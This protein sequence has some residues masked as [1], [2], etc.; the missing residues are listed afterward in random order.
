MEHDEKVIAEL[1]ALR[2][3]VEGMKAQIAA[4]K[5]ERLAYSFAEAGERIGRSSRTISRMVRANEME[6]VTIGNKQMIP[7]SELLRITTP[8]KQL[9][10]G[11]PP[12]KSGGG[13][14]ATRAS[15]EAMLKRRGR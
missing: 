2:L 9:P 15:V 5:L 14:P 12:R 11:R 10:R 3:A 1:L 4:T 7:A 8:K 6:T 13:K